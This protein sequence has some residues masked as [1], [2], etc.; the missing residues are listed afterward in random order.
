MMSA[1]RLAFIPLLLTF[2]TA[3]RAQSPST[4]S[5][6]P[7]PAVS[8][9]CK[10][11]KPR[12]KQECMKVAKQMERSAAAPHDPASTTPASS[13]PSSETVHHSSPVMQTP[14]EK[15]AAREKAP[16]PK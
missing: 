10:D 14:E 1:A 11:L 8:S 4:P 15:K 2:V 12:A 9:D 16:P 13:G 3:T 6:T 5:A 7:P